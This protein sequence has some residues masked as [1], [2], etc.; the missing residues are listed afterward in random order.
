MGDGI[1]EPN[2]LEVCPRLVEK[3]VQANRFPC[4]VWR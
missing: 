4:L 2:N 3:N 1:I